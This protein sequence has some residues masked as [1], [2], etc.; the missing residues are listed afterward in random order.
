M[1]IAQLLSARSMNGAA[2]HCLAIC[3]DLAERG[4]QVLLVHRPEIGALLEAPGVERFGTGFE[5]TLGPLSRIDR[6]LRAFGAEVMHTHMSSAHSYGAVLRLW[7]GLPVVAT[8]HSR[9][10]QLH[11]MVN[12]RVIA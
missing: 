5:R 6:R 12:D 1:R 11:W 8:A 10:F 9:H 4:Y 7:R 3:A 2:R